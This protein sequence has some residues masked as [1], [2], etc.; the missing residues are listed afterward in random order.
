MTTS[1][2]TS[3]RDAALK[4]IIYGD[5]L[6]STASV[7]DVAGTVD[8][9]YH[10]PFDATSTS[11]DSARVV[12]WASAYGTNYNCT[13]PP[14]VNTTLRCDDP[15]DN[16]SSAPA[17]TVMSTMSLDRVESYVGNDASS[18]AY[19]YAFKY[20][21]GTFKD[22]PFSICYDPYTLAQEYCAGEHLLM[23]VTPWVFQ[24]TGGK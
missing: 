14:P 12:Q 5:G 21:N 11:G 17:P 7:T 20:V 24:S 15:L 18:Q 9:I 23:S 4:Q 19:R 3:I 8:F 16:G 10:A 6:G 2:Q 13:T 1:G 22:N